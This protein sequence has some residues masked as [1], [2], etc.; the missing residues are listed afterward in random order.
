MHSKCMVIMG[1]RGTFYLAISRSNLKV[2]P[3]HKSFSSRQCACASLPAWLAWHRAGE[4]S[5]YN[6]S[7]SER[8]GEL[9]G[10]G[11]GQENCKRNGD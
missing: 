9:A 4:K 10:E 5:P 3:V 8:E 7:V 6:P 2:K 1:I 11:N